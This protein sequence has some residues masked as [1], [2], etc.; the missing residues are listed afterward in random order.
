MLALIQL[1]E[2]AVTL[3]MAK[4]RAGSQHRRNVSEITHRPVSCA[5]NNI[6]V[7]EHFS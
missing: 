5:A 4:C 7:N 2:G 3:Y 6:E 1:I